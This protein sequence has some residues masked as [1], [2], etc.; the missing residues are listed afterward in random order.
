MI[1]NEGEVTVNLEDDIDTKME[2]IFGNEE[3][4]EEDGNDSDAEDTEFH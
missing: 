1:Q 3:L 2:S 4:D